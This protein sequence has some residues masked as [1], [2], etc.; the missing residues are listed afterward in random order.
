MTLMDTPAVAVLLFPGTNCEHETVR[1]LR[2]VGMQAD[3]VRWNE[4]PQVLDRYDGYV[5]PGGFSYEDRGRSGLVASFDSMMD[6]IADQARTGKVVIGICNG[7]Q[8]LVDKGLVPG[9]ERLAMGWNVRMKEGKVQGRWVSR[10]PYMKMGGKMKE[11][12]GK[13]VVMQ[14]PVSHGEG[15][16]ASLDEEVF[17]E[18]EKNGQIVLQYCDGEGQVTE[19][20]PTTPNGSPKAIAGI[21]NPE[22]NVVAFMPHPERVYPREGY[23]HSD[24]VFEWMKMKIEQQKQTNVNG[25]EGFTIGG[26][27]PFEV[28]FDEKPKVDLEILTELLITDNESWTIE[29]LAKELAPG[30]RLMK[31]VWWGIESQESKDES[32]ESLAVE[33]LKTGE[34]ANLNKEKARVVIGGE[35]LVYDKSSKTL[36][37]DVGTEKELSRILVI[38]RDDTIG[39]T[40]TALFA[41]HHLD[42]GVSGIQRGVLWTIGGVDKEKV[43]DLIGVGVFH[44]PASM[45]I[46]RH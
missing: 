33:V 25:A 16:F 43:M 46:M 12:F 44:N 36:L 34:L 30:V 35:Q 9:E 7:C 27:E 4:E 2:R 38:E 41:E 8:M 18:L 19:E 24:A 37:G 32:L 1:A 45:V 39:K 5:L 31:Q 40:K 28:S 14:A 15:R 22:G 29:H 3:I 26:G 13:E 42:L 17:D 20:Y 11:E 10:T 21:C 23:E 6:A